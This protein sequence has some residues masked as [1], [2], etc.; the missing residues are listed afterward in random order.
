[1]TLRG[2][3]SREGRE[4]GRHCVI[5]FRARSLLAF[6]AYAA[7]KSLLS[8]LIY[9]ANSNLVRKKR[10]LEF[11]NRN[12]YNF[13]TMNLHILFYENTDRFIKIILN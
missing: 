1:M 3:E 7:Q 2:C 12:Y 6:R 9:I 10:H 5:R 8:R 13:I 11:G 4:N